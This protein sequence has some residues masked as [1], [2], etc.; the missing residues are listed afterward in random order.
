M[1][2]DE[3]AEEQ[4]DSVNGASASR[5]TAKDPLPAIGERWLTTPAAAEDV[6]VQR[7][8]LEQL[9]SVPGSGRS[10]GHQQAGFSGRTTPVRTPAQVAGFHSML[11]LPCCAVA[12]RHLPTCQARNATRV[13]SLFL[14]L[15]SWCN[16][17]RQGDPAPQAGQWTCE[18]ARQNACEWTQLVC[19]DGE[20]GRGGRAA[21]RCGRLEQG[22][23]LPEARVA[24]GPGRAGGWHR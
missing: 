2:Q 7:E 11:M 9:V 19:L 8:R 6:S 5:S 20:G 21:G 4:A 15:S 12:Q 3:E 14:K 23:A 10:Y 24:Q 22:A 1:Q 13:P 16:T 17:G 18:W